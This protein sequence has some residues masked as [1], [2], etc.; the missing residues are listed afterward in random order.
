MEVLQFMINSVEQRK[1]SLAVR[2]TLVAFANGIVVAAA[3]PIATALFGESGPIGY[4]QLLL[5]IPLVLAI[6]TALISVFL[7]IQGVLN[8]W[9]QEVMFG[10][11]DRGF[12][13]PKTALD[14]WPTSVAFAQNFERYLASPEFLQRSA[15]H[16]HL[17]QR[18][19]GVRYKKVRQACWVLIGSFTFLVVAFLAGFLHRVS[20]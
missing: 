1:A 10:K 6:V 17:I 14:D 20:L 4:S 2:A 15:E 3:P 11:V 19:Y 13:H 12:W 16:L 8:L 18:E 7:A 9:P 5:G